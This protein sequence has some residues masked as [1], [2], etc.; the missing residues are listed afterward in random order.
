MEWT[1]RNDLT[2]S[3]RRDVEAFFFGFLTNSACMLFYLLYKGVDIG[4]PYLAT[5]VSGL[6]GLLVFTWLRGKFDLLAILVGVIV[7]GV[8]TLLAKHS[9][10]IEPRVLFDLISNVQVRHLVIGVVGG[11]LLV[12]GA[13]LHSIFLRRDQEPK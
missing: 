6:A 10:S 2:P 7:V 11:P 12:W 5:F 13:A 8:Q 3:Q 1:L 9:F 4:V